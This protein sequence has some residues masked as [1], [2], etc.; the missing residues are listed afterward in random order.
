MPTRD[1]FR[2]VGLPIIGK[3]YR[4]KTHKNWT[5][6]S[7]FTPQRCRQFNKKGWLITNSATKKLYVSND[8]AKTFT[9]VY[10]YTNTYSQAN[11]FDPSLTSTVLFI[12]Y[13]TDNT[14]IIRSSDN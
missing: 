3:A 6:I 13:K 2:E 8:K 5:Q 1:V 14:K 10:T 9:D 12:H 4:S 7:S 11:R